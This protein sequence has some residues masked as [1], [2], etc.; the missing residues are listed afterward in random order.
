MVIIFM[1]K[2]FDAQLM[3]NSRSQQAVHEISCRPPSLNLMDNGNH[4][5]SLAVHNEI[6][7]MPQAAAVCLGFKIFAS[8]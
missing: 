1:L 4:A 8:N 6:P 7:Q 2:H 5:Y 3:L